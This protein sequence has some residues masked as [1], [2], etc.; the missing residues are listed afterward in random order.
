MRVR[1]RARLTATAAAVLLG[2]V[3]EPE[4]QESARPGLQYWVVDDSTKILPGTELGASGGNVE[5]AGAGGETVAFQLVLESALARSRVR[6]G[7]TD[8]KSGDAVVAPHRF[9]LFLETYIDCPAVDAKMVG[10]GPGRY[11]DPLVPLWMDGPGSREVAHP[12]EL[13]PSQRRVLWVD[14]RIPREQGPGR[15][16]G[17]IEI[18]LGSDETV[19]IGIVLERYAFD[20]PAEPSLPAWVPL[21]PTRYRERENVASLGPQDAFD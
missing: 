21:Y 18:E 13:P 15:Y 20:L 2:F 5:L 19:P 9:E 3:S 1:G 4:A 14:I 6:V 12:L 16:E 7:V 10:L 11:P 8:L 17:K